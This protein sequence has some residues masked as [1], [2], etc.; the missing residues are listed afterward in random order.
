MAMANK[1]A[2]LKLRRALLLYILGFTLLFLGAW[3]SLVYS[4]Q[5]KSNISS[6]SP[7]IAVFFLTLGAIATLVGTSNLFAGFKAIRP[8]D[9][10]YDI[11][12]YGALIQFASSIL[13][14]LGL[15]FVIFSSSI[16]LQQLG[17]ELTFAGYLIG[18][19]GALPV[20]IAFYK[21]GKRYKV[22]MIR[23][24]AAVY[25]VLPIVG[26]LMLYFGLKEIVDE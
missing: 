2:I 17:P 12:I 15:Y 5:I 18:F 23:V 4:N 20:A 26:P 22:L 16:S 25:F 19:A 13:F 6:A 1:F 14:V 3:A 7:V 24:G 8:V 9:K 21:L 11:G 10:I